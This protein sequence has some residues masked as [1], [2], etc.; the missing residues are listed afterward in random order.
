MG[1]SLPLLE[2]SRQTPACSIRDSAKQHA[3]LTSLFSTIPPERMGLN[4]EYD[5]S[6]LAKRVMVAFQENFA[7][8]DLQQLS[9]AQRGRVVI[10]KGTLPNSN[11]L[12]QLVAIARNVHGATDVE[13][14]T[15]ITAQ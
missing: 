7:L 11:L 1:S 13:T 9:V 2:S 15:I 10:L 14:Y 4:G 12:T 5:H 8:E 3:S 6:G